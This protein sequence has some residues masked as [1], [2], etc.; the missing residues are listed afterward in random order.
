MA[1]QIE[2]VYERILECAKKEF[3]EK[4]Y[5]DASLRTIAAEANTS[6]NSIYVRFKD[7]E[8]LFEAIVGP[9]LNGLIDIFNSY[10][11]NFHSFDSE[12][13][14]KC[15]NEYSFE[16]MDKL[17]D[18]MYDNFDEFLLLLDASHGTRFQNFIDELTRIEVEYTYKYIECVGLSKGEMSEITEDFV[19]IVTTA[20][21]EGVFEVIRHRMD[22][23]T[24]GKYIGMLERYYAAGFDTFLNFKQY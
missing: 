23:E 12:T 9:V 17:L 7:K 13:Q 22:R 15:V 8:G 18:Y 24:A 16:G 19:H 11:E 10:Q 14:R 4:G 1:K 21:F 3:L 6:T 5:R 20:Y 2:G